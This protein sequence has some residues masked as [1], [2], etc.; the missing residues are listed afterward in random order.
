[1]YE[2]VIQKLSIMADPSWALGT[3]SRDLTDEII[4]MTHTLAVLI[5]RL[6]I[7]GSPRSRAPLD[8]LLVTFHEHFRIAREVF[9]PE[10]KKNLIPALL[11]S[12]GKSLVEF[13][14][15]VREEMGVDFLDKKIKR[16]SAK[17]KKQKKT[18]PYYDI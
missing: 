2:E 12:I 8:A 6:F 4:K 5:N 9:F 18:N 10:A 16:D 13:M 11:S 7:Y 1:V 14:K 17:N 15:T 3:P